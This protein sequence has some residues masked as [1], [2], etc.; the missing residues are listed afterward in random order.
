MLRI[1]FS[2]NVVVVLR[3]VLQKIVDS[4]AMTPSGHC[5][6]EVEALLT[7]FSGRVQSWAFRGGL[8]ILC[9]YFFDGEFKVGVES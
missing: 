4:F 8:S 7:C 2:I 3:R 1:I 6:G 5:L 9:D